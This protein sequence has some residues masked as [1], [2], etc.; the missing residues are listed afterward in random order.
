MLHA[1]EKGKLENTLRERERE[2]LEQ[3]Q[4]KIRNME[5]AG[6]RRLQDSL[7]SRERDMEKSLAAHSEQ[8]LLALEEQLGQQKRSLA[9]EVGNLVQSKTSLEARAASLL[10]EVSDL[11]AKSENLRQRQQEASQDL[12]RMLA[13][14]SLAK[15]PGRTTGAIVPL[16]GPKTRGKSVSASEVNELILKTPLLTP[17]GRLLM[18]RFIILLLAGD[19]PVLRGPE[20]NAFLRIAETMVSSGWSASME[21][22]PTMITFEDLWV[23]AG[24]SVPTALGRALQLCGPEG[25]TTCLAV[26]KNIERSGARFWFPTVAERSRRSEFPRRFLLAMTIGDGE[27]EEVLP[28]SREAINLEIKGAIEVLA[29]RMAPLTIRPEVSH[30]LD[31]GDDPQSIQQAAL[32]TSGLAD[33][34]DVNLALRATRVAA[35]ASRLADGDGQKTIVVS[36]IEFFLNNSGTGAMSKDSLLGGLTNA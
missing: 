18:Q 1:Q 9:D 2:A 15:E 34:T 14:R 6:S 4:E 29:P 22:D 19:I 17:H 21:S 16:S 5:E 13:A 26:I 28:I 33:C 36:T 7:A 35:E 24:T 31:P 32:L 8:G 25:D 23:R 20:V 12:D 10:E 30:E 11:E 3:L 27:C